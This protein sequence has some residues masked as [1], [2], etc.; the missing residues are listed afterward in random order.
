MPS[1][2][3]INTSPLFSPMRHIDITV[4]SNG[5]IVYTASSFPV[6][7]YGCC[8]KR[9]ITRDTFQVK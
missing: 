6:S 8:C 3:I 9:G 5:S 2:N 1:M 7:H 4:P